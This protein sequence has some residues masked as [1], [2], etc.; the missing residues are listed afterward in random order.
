[1]EEAMG[2]KDPAV[3]RAKVARWLVAIE[4]MS[5]FQVT[6]LSLRLLREAVRDNLSDDQAQ[7]LRGAIERRVQSIEDDLKTGRITADVLQER[8]A[9][10]ARTP[11]YRV[12][13]K[14][15]KAPAS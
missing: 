2:S 14:R 9:R 11:Y 15:T 7:A 5:M 6:T 3:M 13:P 1:M 12:A 10:S 8:E 4:R